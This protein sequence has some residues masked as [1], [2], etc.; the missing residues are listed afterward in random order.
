MQSRLLEDAA[1][2]KYPDRGRLGLVH[3]PHDNK[4]L[5]VRSGGLQNISNDSRRPDSRANPR[6][7]VSLK[8]RAKPGRKQEL[9]ASPL[10]RRFGLR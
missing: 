1:N 10:E 5:Y 2:L 4:L 7:A 8:T 9:K 3:F 6:G